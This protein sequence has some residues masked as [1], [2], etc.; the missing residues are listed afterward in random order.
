MEIKEVTKTTP[1][2]GIEYG[3]V[4]ANRKR[5][6]EKYVATARKKKVVKAKNVSSMLSI[7]EVMFSISSLSSDR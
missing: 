5:R 3:A 7:S 4:P 1:K 2:R 6:T